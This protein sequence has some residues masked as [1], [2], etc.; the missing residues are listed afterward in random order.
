M[1]VLNKGVCDTGCCKLVCTVGL[2]KESPSITVHSRLDHDQVWYSQRLKGELTH[3]VHPFS[4]R[5][6]APCSVPGHWPHAAKGMCRHLS[7]SLAGHRTSW[8]RHE[9]TRC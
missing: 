6:Q 3:A 4:H 1:V 8:C 2:E 7:T 9:C 5:D